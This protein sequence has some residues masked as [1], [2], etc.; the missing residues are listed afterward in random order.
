MRHCEAHLSHHVLL[1]STF[2]ILITFQMFLLL[3]AHYIGFFGA[4]FLNFI[5]AILIVKRARKLFGAYGHVMLVFAIC[6]MGFSW[7]D[8]L[9]QPVSPKVSSKHYSP[10][11]DSSHE[12]FNADCLHIS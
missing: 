4:Q 12:W 1:R 7:V 10:A 2:L 8:F 11:S 6:S 9:T 5:L 3:L